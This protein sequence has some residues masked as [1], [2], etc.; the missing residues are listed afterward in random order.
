MKQ[1]S[2]YSQTYEN[3]KKNIDS[4]LENNIQNALTG[5]FSNTKDFF[6]DLFS[7]MQQSFTQGL[8]Q[9]MAQAIMSNAVMEAFTHTFSDAMESISGAFGDNVAGGLAGA[10]GVE[11]GTGSAVMGFIGQSAAGATAGYTLGGM[12]ENAL[13]TDGY[14]STVVKNTKALR[15]GMSVGGAAIGAAIGGPVGALIGGTIGGV[16]SSLISSFKTQK[17]S[18]TAQ[19]VQLWDTAT[20]EHI[21]GSLYSDMKKTT[22]SWWG[23]SKKTT[24]WTDYASTDLQ[25]M[26]VIQTTLRSY[27]YLLEDIGA[28]FKEISVSAGRYSSYA[29]IA[30]RGAKSVIAAYLGLDEYV[31]ETYTRTLTFFGRT[32]SLGQ[33]TRWVENSQLNA[34]YNVWASYAKSV[35]KEV[36]EA[37]AESL[38]A[39][40][41]T[42]NTFEAWK[43]EFEGKGTEALE[44]A[45]DLANQQV[46]RILE[47]LGAKDVTIDNYLQFREEMLKK[48]FDP[49]T[50]EYLNTLGEYLM[51]AAEATQKYEDALKEETKTKLNLID[52]FL[53]K[54]AKIDD[55]AAS[56]ADSQ[57]KISISILS[58]LKQMLRIEQENQNEL[59]GQP[60]LAVARA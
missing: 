47:T 2:E 17:I 53:A 18:Q 29:D 51:S 59:Y 36:S 55:F 8:A 38:Q 28:G 41:D 56:N 60:A 20:K 22:K 33:A 21:S 34:I 5:K 10:S 11:G 1:I 6:K 24:R 30:N 57:E 49:Q 16:A 31:K 7:S 37:L 42:G 14:E 27:E 19:G 44:F 3:L 32:F 9:S 43:L 12:L 4:A 26:R 25:S 58:T 15:A 23:L 48:S 52:P 40:V 46:E 45:A 54:T 35:N 39:Y 13:I 50:I